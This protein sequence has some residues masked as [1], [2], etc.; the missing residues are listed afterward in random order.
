M[1][2]VCYSVAISCTLEEITNIQVLLHKGVGG[3]EAHNY[4]RLKIKMKNVLTE[5][6]NSLRRKKEMI[7]CASEYVYM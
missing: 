3:P 7:I 6:A 4:E 1:Y 2:A 5:E